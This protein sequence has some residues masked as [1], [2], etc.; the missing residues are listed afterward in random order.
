LSSFSTST[1]SFDPTTRPA[2]V[3]SFAAST[4]SVPSPARY[5]FRRSALSGVTTAMPTHWSDMSVRYREVRSE[6]PRA[7]FPDVGNQYRTSDPS[8]A[9]APGPITF[10]G[11]WYT[12]AGFDDPPVAP[13]MPP[14]PPPPHVAKDT[15]L[16]SAA[17]SASATARWAGR[18]M[19]VLPAGVTSRPIIA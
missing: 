5:L 8:T 10:H 4:T 12:S 2:S 16:A 3:P 6:H 15:G 17:T 7:S 11:T 13:P 1:A 18:I 19:F 14:P 9:G